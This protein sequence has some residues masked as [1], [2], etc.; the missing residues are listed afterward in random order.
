[1]KKIKSIISLVLLVVIFSASSYAGGKEFK[2]IIIYNI[3]FGEDMDP[4]MLSMMPKTMKMYISGDKQRVEINTGF[5]N[6]N[7]IYDA[8]TNEAVVLMDMMGQKFALKTSA[9]DL[10]KEMAEAPE[11]T[12]EVTDETKE[13]A[14]YTCKKAIVK[15]KDEEGSE[16]IVYFTDE[17]GS[18]VLNENN[19]LYKKIDG[20]MLEFVTTEN[21]VEMSFKAISVDKKKVSDD[22]FEIPEGY[23]I[24][25]EEELQNMFGG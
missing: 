20:V 15:L 14:G 19:P 11:T 4:A 8:S 6:T 9:E 23:K 12:I 10:E 17:L 25:T 22:L 16:F 21:D 13:I 3:S 1:M 2:G 7:A 5:G 24:V 18:S